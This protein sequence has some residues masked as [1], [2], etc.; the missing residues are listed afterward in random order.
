[1]PST[2]NALD[3]DWL[4]VCRGTADD[5]RAVLA[6]R[7]TTAQRV[8]ETGVR[9]RGG[10]RTL[11][12]DQAAEDALMARLRGLHDAGHRFNVVSEECGAIDFG[13]P[14][15]RVVV[16]PIDGSTNAKRGLPY[17]LS[18]AVADGDTMA[19]VAFGFVHDFGTGE[20]WVA[21]RGEGVL[22]DGEPAPDPGDE[23]R[24]RDGRLELLA[25]ESADPRWVAR[26]IGDLAEV[27]HRLRCVGAIAISLCQ[28]A[29][30]RVDGMAT[31][32]RSRAV[33]C[34]A[35]QLIA[36]ESGAHV[37]FP[38]YPELSAPL[39]LEPRAP[40]LAARTADG[41]E[42]LRAVPIGPAT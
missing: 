20:E 4:G 10:D 17:A 42:R 14:G 3:A 22:L 11:V 25:I 2:R 41:L 7:P 18:I 31:L 24:D 6:N 23:R 12:I 34:A 15:V 8:A 37:A 21:R 27:A 38:G 16:D 5:L 1:M 36:R 26:A 33:D 29:A 32:W 28:V 30:G 9:G 40:V 19:D 35:G 13:D 39:D